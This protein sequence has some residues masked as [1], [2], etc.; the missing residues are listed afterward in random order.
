MDGHSFRGTV[1][2]KLL[3]IGLMATFLIFDTTIAEEFKASNVTE[4]DTVRT[5]N[6]PDVQ[7]PLRFISIEPTV[8]LIKDKS[9]L[10]Q[11]VN[12]TI[13]NT[14]KPVEAMLEVILSSKKRIVTLV[15]VEN[16]K[17]TVQVHIPEASEPTPVELTLKADGKVQDNRKMTWQPQRHWK[18][19]IVPIT[20]HDLG[21]TDTIENVLHSYDGFYDDICVSA[22]RQKIGR[23]NRSI[24]TQSREPGRSSTLS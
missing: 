12:V 21:Y 8:F 3:C 1:K 7:L 15:K 24:D 14:A 9:S 17:S 10:L 13:D 16:G 5:E 4:A 23:T 22:N 11:V 18:V 2:L 20:H 19:Y 6:L